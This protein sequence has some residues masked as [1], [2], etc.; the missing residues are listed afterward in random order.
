MEK[1]NYIDP[2][3]YHDNYIHNKKTKNPEINKKLLK[4]YDNRKIKN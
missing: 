2:F 1:H 4:I 3:T